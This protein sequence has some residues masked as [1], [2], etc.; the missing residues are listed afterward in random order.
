MHKLK[1]QIHFIRL[2]K[3]LWLFKNI[4]R[5]DLGQN[6]Y[7]QFILAVKGCLKFQFIEL[8]RIL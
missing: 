3:A 1:Y 4:K 2:I 8:K 5:I 7:Y 6:N